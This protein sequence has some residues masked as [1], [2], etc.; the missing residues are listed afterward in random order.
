MATLR[1]QVYF[2]STNPSYEKHNKEI[3]YQ[4]V[5]LNPELGPFSRKPRISMHQMLS[6]KNYTSRTT[7]KTSTVQEGQYRLY[8]RPIME[9]LTS[10]GMKLV[11]SL[12]LIPMKVTSPALISAAGR[13]SP[14]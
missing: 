2:Q 4:F 1:Y 5:V 14:A 6:I 12:A 11:T 9:H 7:P 3:R 13:P 10:T 8:I